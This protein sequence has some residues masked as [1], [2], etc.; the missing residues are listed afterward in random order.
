MTF[1]VGLEDFYQ[2][3][4]EKEEYSRRRESSEQSHR[5]PEGYASFRELMLIVGVRRAGWSDMTFSTDFLKLVWNDP[6]Q[7]HP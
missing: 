6:I 1:Q 7:N 4:R 5:G 2:M 3:D